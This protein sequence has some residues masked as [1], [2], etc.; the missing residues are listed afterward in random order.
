MRNWRWFNSMTKGWYYYYFTTHAEW[1]L[2]TGRKC[3]LTVYINSLTTYSLLVFAIHANIHATKME[4]SGK[5]TNPFARVLLFYYLYQRSKITATDFEKI[6]KKYAGKGDKLLVDLQTKYTFPIP[7]SVWSLELARLCAIYPIP[8]LFLRLMSMSEPPFD[9]RTDVYSSEFKAE[10]VLFS[11]SISV[12][13]RNAPLKD[14]L[15]RVR[16]ILPGYSGPGPREV[17]SCSTL[18]SSTSASSLSDPNAPPKAR[19]LFEL[20]AEEAQR[21]KLSRGG[22]NSEAGP[23][24]L[25]LLA[26][27]MRDRVRVRIVLRR[28]NR[29][30]SNYRY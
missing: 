5:S 10:H 1:V 24:P 9:V 27:F 13:Y 22:D 12:S 2:F 11:G 26:Q 3:Q 20:I 18:T 30:G 23:S 8:P 17:P 14:N 19:H 16:Y 29:L 15:S 4:K 25:A 21:P 7:E 28:H 6:A